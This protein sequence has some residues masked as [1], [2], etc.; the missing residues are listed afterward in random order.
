MIAL[1]GPA[2]CREPAA[3]LADEHGRFWLQM[4]CVSTGQC[5][6]SELITLLSEDMRQQAPPG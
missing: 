4:A 5:S 6:A 3:K 2:D 1:K